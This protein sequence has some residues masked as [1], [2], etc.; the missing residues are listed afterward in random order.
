MSRDGP[1]VGE[2]N[3]GGGGSPV[4]GNDLN[5]CGPPPNLESV[6]PPVEPP[7]EPPIEPTPGDP[8]VTIFDWTKDVH[9]GDLKG[10]VIHMEG[11]S[12]YP[13][14]EFELG[15]ND[16]APPIRLQLPPPYPPDGR[17]FRVLSFKPV[18]T[19]DWLLTVKV[20]NEQGHWGQSEGTYPVTVRG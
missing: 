8:S 1:S 18:R 17:Y 2:W 7:I 10:I 15:L 19:G 5:R 3:A 9:R 14:T 4:T 12:R 6:E 16:G 20:K 13:V 11:M